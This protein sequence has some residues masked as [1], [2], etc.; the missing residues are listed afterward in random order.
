M[1]SVAR[2]L[3]NWDILLFQP[4]NYDIFTDQAHLRIKW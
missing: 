4:E 3:G 1:S 2:H